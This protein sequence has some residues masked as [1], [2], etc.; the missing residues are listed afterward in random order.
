MKKTILLL[1][2]SFCFV[3]AHAQ[4][5]MSIFPQPGHVPVTSSQSIN[6]SGTVYWICSGL[7]VTILSSQGDVYL[8]ESNVT[9]NITGSA[10]DQVYAKAGCVI[11]NSSSADIGV[12][13]DPSNV[14]LNNTGTG[15]LTVDLICTPV[16]YDY[17]MIGGPG[18]CAGSSGI[19]ENILTGVSTYPN[20]FVSSLLIA[21]IKTEGEAVLYNILGDEVAAWKISAG[22]NKIEA[23]NIPS[24]VYFLKIKT[25]EG[26]ATMKLMKQ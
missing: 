18:S 10:G 1:A 14:T 16:V 6:A 24:G 20:P 7:T 25:T 15:T 4:C 17:S 19:E 11:N 26:V 12:A 22:E 5:T 23:A 2:S 13:C 8:C 9:L 3:F 21:G